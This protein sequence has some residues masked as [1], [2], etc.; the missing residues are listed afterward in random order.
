[1]RAAL[2]RVD[3]VG[4]GIDRFRIA[5]VPLQ[6]NLGIDAVLLAPH[7]DRLVVDSDLVLVQVLDE[8]NDAPL[9]LKLVALAI[10]L[11]IQRDENA[12]IQERQ[13]AKPLG[14]RIEAEFDRFKNLGIRLEGDLGAPA[15]CR[16]RDLELARWL[17]ALVALLVDLI[18]APDLKVEFLRQ[19]VDD[20]DADAVQTTRHFITLVVELA[21]GVQ[22]RHD[23][24]G[25]GFPARV[26]IDR[27]ASPVV[28]HGDRVV[29]VN[30]DVDLVAEAGQRLVDGIVDNLVDEMM[31]AGRA[32][33]PDVH[34]G[35][36]PNGF[37]PLENFDLVGAV[38][39]ARS[40][41]PCPPV[42]Y[43]RCRVLCDVVF[44]SLLRSIV[45]GSQ[46]AVDSNAIAPGHRVLGFHC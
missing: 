38:G 18:V 20:R 36:L 30:G 33:R 11:I 29:D 25:R 15:L 9:V 37:Q 16:A 39:I 46:L 43:V 1:M 2:V 10:A 8:R 27:N 23:D 22:H 14:K 19:R 3:V 42:G 24:F 34:R 12:R 4:E 31:Q 41:G 26:L 45:G 7:V 13:L 5:V 6:G 21:P 28:D 17:P 40:R 35:P 44:H 32:G